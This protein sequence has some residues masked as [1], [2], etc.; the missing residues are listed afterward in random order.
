M[1][2][3]GLTCLQA[4]VYL[5]L[6]RMEKATAKMISKDSQIDRAE[7]Y[8]TLSG[9]H[10]LGLVE[11]VVNAPTFFRALPV[12]EALPMLLRRKGKE[13]NEIKE[14]TEDLLENLKRVHNEEKTRWMDEGQF[15]IFPEKERSLH[16]FRK[17]VENAEISVDMILHGVCFNYGMTE[18]A[19]LWKKAVEKG[20][21][22]RFI[23]YKPEND[24]AVLRTVQF[25]KR[26]GSFNIR[27][28]LSPP[29]ATIAIFDGKEILVSTSPNPDPAKT[30]RLWSNNPGLVTIIQSYFELM[31][32]KTEKIRNKK[33]LLHPE[34][35]NYMS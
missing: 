6:A 31:W 4:R 5:A 29:P 28:C 34:Q 7:V 8:R 25:F 1:T 2:R 30:S 33:C 12:Q 15:I 32:R 18:D 13:Y 27:Y 20:V 9:L 26:K 22:I 11:K 21:K 16:K 35:L 14:K 10:Q 19:W 24:K 17:M 3:L 23:I